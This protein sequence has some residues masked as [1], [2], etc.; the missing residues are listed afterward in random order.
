MESFRTPNI[1]KEDNMDID[2]M[3]YEG[4]EIKLDKVRHIKYTF[5]GMKFLAKKYGSVIDA[6]KKL[7]EIDHNITAEGIDDLTNLIYAGLIHEDKEITTDSVEDAL[8]FN[9]IYP[10]ISKITKA[11]Y[12]SSPQPKGG[13]EGTTGE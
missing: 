11:F 8:D 10:V 3:N 2:D 9:N 5:K 4:E 13:S 12:V 6:M 7:E 1:L